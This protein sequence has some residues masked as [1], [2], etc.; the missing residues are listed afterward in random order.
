MKFTFAAIALSA[1]VAIVH[2]QTAGSLGSAV[3]PLKYHEDAVGRLDSV[4]KIAKR[5][6]IAASSNVS[7]LD[8]NEPAILVA[9]QEA[10]GLEK[11][12]SRAHVEIDAKIDL[13]I[14]AIVEACADVK[15]NLKAKIVAKIVARPNVHSRV[16]AKIEG[17]FFLCCFHKF[18]VA[19][20]I[21]SH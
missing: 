2:A 4:A 19:A 9:T 18:R 8:S 14:K 16:K 7:P 10:P 12:G 20:S 13:V 1:V 21:P 17:N 15:I 6:D 11:R 5:V 3:F